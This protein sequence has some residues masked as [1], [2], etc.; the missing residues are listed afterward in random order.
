MGNRAIFV[1]ALL[2]L[3]LPLALGACGSGDSKQTINGQVVALDAQAQ[4]FSVET[5]DGKRYDFKKKS[6]SDVD[7]THIKEH[8]DEKKSIKVEFTGNSSPYEASY[9]H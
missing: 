2:L 3:A 1:A 4:T 8:M 5:S 6:G 7:L 9:A